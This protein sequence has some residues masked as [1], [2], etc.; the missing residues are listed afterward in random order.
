MLVTG[1][2]GRV[3][4][5]IKAIQ[6]NSERQ[7]VTETKVEI[8]QEDVREILEIVRELDKRN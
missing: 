2:S 3:E 1:V 4:S 7:A 5:N 8:M 6:I